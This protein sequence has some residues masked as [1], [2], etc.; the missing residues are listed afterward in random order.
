VALLTYI[1]IFILVSIILMII[2][3]QGLKSHPVPA[4]GDWEN[5][6]ILVARRTS[7]P[8]Q[9]DMSRRSRCI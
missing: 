3:G 6:K 8:G 2:P 1:S 7:R 4:L 9:I 5:I